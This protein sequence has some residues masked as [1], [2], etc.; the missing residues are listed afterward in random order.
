[1]DYITQDGQNLIRDWYVGLDDDSIRARFDTTLAIL[2]ATND[3]TARG[4]EEFKILTGAHAGLSEIRINMKVNSRKRRFRP[5]GLWSEEESLFIFLL[6]CEKSGR[7]H[8]PQNAFNLALHYK[9][10]YEQGVGGL[11]EHI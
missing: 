9:T 7:I 8:M 1:M 4:M 2:G 6:G 10:Q 11:C 5:V 3:W